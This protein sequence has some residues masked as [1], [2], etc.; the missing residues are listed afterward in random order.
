MK[1]AATSTTPMVTGDRLIQFR[2]VRRLVARTLA[3]NA[4]QRPRPAPSPG[5]PRWRP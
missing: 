4:Q 5:A 2:T 1:P 3:G